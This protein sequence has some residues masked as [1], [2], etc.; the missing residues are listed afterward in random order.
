MGTRQLTQGSEEDFL[1]ALRP[2]RRVIQAR[3]LADDEA[4]DA[5]QESFLRLWEVRERLDR[6]VL[7]AYGVVVAKNVVSSRTRAQA[8]SDRHAPRLVDP[9]SVPGP[10]SAVLDSE[11]QRAVAVALRELPENDRNVLLQHELEDVPLQTLAAKTGQSPSALAARLARARARLRVEHLLA[12]R[13]VTLPTP[14]CRP[15]LTSISQRDKR[16]QQRVNAGEH[17][18]QCPTCEELARPLL[19]RRRSLAALAPIPWLIALWGLLHDAF[20]RPSLVAVWDL[21]RGAFRRPT[22]QVAAGG[23]AAATAATYGV[24]TL[25]PTEQA[26]P[27]AEPSAPTSAPPSPAPAAP[28]PP[29]GTLR[30]GTQTVLPA[31]SVGRLDAFVGMTAEAIRVPVESTPADEG[32]WVGTSTA[33]VWVQLATPVESPPDVEPGHLVSFTGIVTGTTLDTPGL[34]GMNDAEGAGTLLVESAYVVVDVEQL[35]IN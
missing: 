2:M 11:E 18:L 5:L 35:T 24:M 15:V 23:V 16:Q 33:R 26:P 34:V 19:L 27:A 31:S 12:M 8:L 13:R 1:A 14:V 32:F 20:R 29:D 17:L 30:F 3:G 28:V 21:L 22:V 10:E 7:I 4:D 9:D 6:H 25:G